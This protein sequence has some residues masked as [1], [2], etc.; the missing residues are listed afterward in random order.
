M[1]QIQGVCLPDHDTLFAY[2][3]SKG[4]LLY[5][6][7]G[8]Y[9]LKKIEQALKVVDHSATALDIGAHVGLWSMILKDH[10][11]RVLAFE[12]VP[13]HVACFHLNLQDS[14]DFGQGKGNVEVY[15]IALGSVH[16]KVLINPVPDNSGNA[17]VETVKMEGHN[18]VEVEQHLL[19]DWYVGGPIS[20]IKIDVEGYEL[21][22]IKGAE[23]T[24]RLHRPVIVVEQKPGNAKKYG[25]KTTEAVELLQKWGAKVQWEMSGDYCLKF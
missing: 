4:P 8:T 2:H 11:E 9:Q 10:F 17:Y 16:K 15:P 3:L 20:F 19:D 6:G 14:I 24:I 18:L 23:D 22:V 12:P 21:E 25:F 1:K 13:E 5:D 7:R